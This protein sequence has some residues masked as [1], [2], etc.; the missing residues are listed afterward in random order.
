MDPKI[1]AAVFASI[2]ALAVGTGGT[3]ID[4]FENFQEANPQR[5][6][7]QFM[8]SSTGLLDGFSER[9]DPTNSVKISVKVNS[10]QT[11]LKLRNAELS[12][13]DFTKL[14]S[15]SRTISSD[16]DITFLGFSGDVEIEDDNS[17]LVDG[18]GNGFRSSGVNYTEKLDL[19][20]MTD[21]NDI[22]ADD[23]EK[24]KFELANVNVEMESKTGSTVIQKGNSSLK[25]NS[26]SGDVRIYPEN[27]SFVLDGKVARL[28]A[29]GTEFTG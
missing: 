9:P 23:V 20:F 8:G 17:T 13:E 12:I 7:G 3:S 19:R 14:K 10:D 4:N 21:S 25:I 28:E 27:M 11:D 16:E 22:Y 6:I 1:L 15:P 24:T 18:V 26:F 29:G 2:A 5:M